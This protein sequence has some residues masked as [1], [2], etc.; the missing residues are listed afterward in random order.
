MERN[1]HECGIHFLAALPLQYFCLGCRE[2]PVDILRRV[3]SK[4]MS[5]V[6]IG[7]WETRRRNKA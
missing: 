5:E 4:P 3:Y 1:C 7:G 2:K 6:A